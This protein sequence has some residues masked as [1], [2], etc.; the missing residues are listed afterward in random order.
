MRSHDRAGRQDTSAQRDAM[1]CLSAALRMRSRPVATNETNR[2]VCSA[3]GRLM[4][5]LGLALTRDA[6]SIPAPVRLAVVHLAHE[7][8]TSPSPPTVESP[9]D[10][11]ARHDTNGT[12]APSPQNVPFTA[13]IRLGRMG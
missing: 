2:R 8:Q 13:S 1:T 6:A 4:E 7:L 11:R 5:A 3:V 10:P 12:A 9:V